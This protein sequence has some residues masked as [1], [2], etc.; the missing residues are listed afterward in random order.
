MQ[1]Q[2]TENNF[3]ASNTTRQRKM[4]RITSQDGRQLL[5]LSPFICVFIGVV[6]TVVGETAS[7]NACT[8][9]G[10]TVM[11]FGGLLLV[12]ITVW[13]SRQD[14]IT[15]RQESTNTGEHHVDQ[16][17]SGE[18]SNYQL[19][20]IHHFEVWIPSEFSGQEMVPPSYEE[21]VNE[22][23]TDSLQAKSIVACDIVPSSEAPSHEENR[24]SVQDV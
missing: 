23:K 12:F 18:D 10:P 22:K 2:G 3:D 13:N 5:L 15:S 4:K 1:S 6:L 14:Q 8:I 16:T 19:G 11:T 7:L 17:L 20:P 24:G 21:S 9:A